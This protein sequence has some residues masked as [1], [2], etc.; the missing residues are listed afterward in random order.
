LSTTS[1]R[2][3]WVGVFAFALVAAG[4]VGCD[5]TP[6]PPDDASASS[7]NPDVPKKG[8]KGFFKPKKGAPTQEPPKPKSKP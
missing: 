8:V 6:A 4:T 5:S 3:A 1:R 7:T 2:F